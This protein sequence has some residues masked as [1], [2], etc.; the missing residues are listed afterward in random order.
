MGGREGTR[1][2]L[3]HEERYK[4]FSISCVS[5]SESEQNL[6]IP[7]ESRSDAIGSLFSNSLNV[8]SLSITILSRASSPL[9][10]ATLFDTSCWL[11]FS[12]SNKEGLFCR[13][14]RKKY[15]RVEVF[16]NK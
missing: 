3:L 8:D 7:S 5:C 2:K 4:S 14:R 16:A 10:I 1:R 15:M 11:C 9:L 12:S 13:V 6:L